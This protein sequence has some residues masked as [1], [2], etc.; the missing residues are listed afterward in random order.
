[1]QNKILFIVWNGEIK[2]LQNSTMDHKEWFLSLGGKIEDYDNVIR[3]Y[4]MEEK[5]IFFK[6]NLNYD[7]EV[8]DFATKMGNKIKN[9]LN[10]P[11][12]KVCCGINPG[13]N[14]SKWEPILV[15]NDQDLEGYKTEEQLEKEKQLQNQ[16]NDNST[17][18]PLIE[19][20][21]DMEDPNFRKY[22][23]TFTLVLFGIAILAKIIMVNNKT[24]MT[25]NRWNYMLILFQSI[26]FILT[27]V[28]Y[29]QKLSKTK[30][31]GIV[32][33]VAS[34]FL[35]DLVDIIVGAVNLFFTIDQSYIV[36]TGDLI[37]KLLHIKKK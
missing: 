29:N 19:F 16:T 7:S 31:F 8:I 14:G 35:F 22:A 28:G 10:A 21:N 26:G 2:F 13:Q 34:F 30:Y 33:S 36:K 18:S 25:N 3:G 27:I 15:L 32:A 4:I 24:L 12:Y 6:A 9:Q 1:M 37:K 5:I 23:T 11:H 17:T 20:K